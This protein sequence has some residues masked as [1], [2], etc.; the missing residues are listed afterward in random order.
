MRRTGSRL[1]SNCNSVP[2]RFVWDSGF[3][4][5][6]CIVISILIELHLVSRKMQKMGKR[7]GV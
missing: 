2:L 5:S 1:S 4:V 3:L 7:N 6:D